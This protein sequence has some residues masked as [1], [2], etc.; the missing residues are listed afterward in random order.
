MNTQWI[1]TADRAPTEADLPVWVWRFGDSNTPVII[2][3]LAFGGLYRITH[4]RPAKADIPEPPNDKTQFDSDQSELSRWLFAQWS[5]V[6]PSPYDT[7]HAALAYEREQVAKM[8]PTKS[9]LGA[10]DVAEMYDAIE[11]IRARCEGGGK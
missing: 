8:L 7:W 9:N 1:R 6:M 4:W 3:N 10:Y 2:H 5:G 11:A